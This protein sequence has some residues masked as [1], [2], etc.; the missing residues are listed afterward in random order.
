MRL[1]RRRL[2]GGELDPELVGLSVLAASGACAAVWLAWKFPT[3]ICIFHA[4]TG[5][6]CVTCGGTRSVKNL[7]AGHV[8]AAF[9]WNPLV[10]LSLAGA[11]V[12]MIY[13]AAVTAFRM[14]RL[15]VVEITASE[16]R[17]LRLAIVLALAANWIY[18]IYRF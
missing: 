12:F 15:R 14:P 5:L 17:A 2:A 9:A 16:A 6:P 4:I 7:L 18:L 11:G 8:G 10:F 3:P 13:A 1:T